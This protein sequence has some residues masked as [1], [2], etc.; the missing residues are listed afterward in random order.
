MTTKAK[1]IAQLFL[2]TIKANP[3]HITEQMANEASV[4]HLFQGYDLPLDDVSRFQRAL[5]LWPEQFKSQ[6]PL[7]NAEIR[8]N[9]RGGT[10]EYKPDPHNFYE[11]YNIAKQYNN[12]PLMLQTIDG[13]YLHPQTDAEAIQAY[14][15]DRGAA[16]VDQAIN[17]GELSPLEYGARGFVKDNLEAI[18][19][20][21]STPEAYA[22]EAAKKYPQNHTVEMADYYKGD[23]W[24]TGETKLKYNPAL[25]ARGS[26]ARFDPRLRFL[27]SKLAAVPLAAP[28][29]Q[30]DPYGTGN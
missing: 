12:E 2:R 15:A 21:Y 14:L 6:H 9:G 22:A 4:P 8:P 28:L 13:D 27:A 20:A 11:N 16:T 3:E 19:R 29:L 30:N 25:N 26:S 1:A 17:D 24:P 5:D 7:N 18:K 23:F 10:Y